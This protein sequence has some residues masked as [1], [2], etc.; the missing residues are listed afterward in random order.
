MTAAADTVVGAVPA[1]RE[2]PTGSLA[3]AVCF[4]LWA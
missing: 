1:A 3:E 4:A 2:A